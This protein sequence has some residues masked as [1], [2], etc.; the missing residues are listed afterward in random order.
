MLQNNT[1]DGAILF[2]GLFSELSPSREANRGFLKMYSL[3][4]MAVGVLQFGRQY[5]EPP[6]GGGKH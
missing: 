1:L 5:L 2:L 3:V 4:P 6:V